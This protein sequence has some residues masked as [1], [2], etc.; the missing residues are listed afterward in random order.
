MDQRTWSFLFHTWIST[1]EERKTVYSM[2]GQKVEQISR[3]REEN[4]LPLLHYNPSL[5]A[6]VIQFFRREARTVLSCL[7]LFWEMFSFWSLF[8][9][10]ELDPLLIKNNCTQ[11]AT[12]VSKVC[13]SA[14]GFHQRQNMSNLPWVVWILHYRGIVSSDKDPHPSSPCWQCKRKGSKVLFFACSATKVKSLVP[15]R[16]F[17]CRAGKVLRLWKIQSEYCS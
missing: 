3:C 8:E 5:Q 6:I 11:W 15:S 4:L 7:V 13:L 12:A 10:T 1:K 2:Q 9:I 16:I 14:Y 17:S